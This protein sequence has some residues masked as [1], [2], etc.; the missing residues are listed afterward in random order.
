MTQISELLAAQGLP[1]DKSAV[2]FDQHHPFLV[3]DVN[4]QFLMATGYSRKEVIGNNLGM[5]GGKETETGI[6]RGIL[7]A[8]HA[9]Q[10]HTATI[11]N[12]TKT[13][14]KVRNELT[15]YVIA[16]A[17]GD[18]P[19][20]LAVGHDYNVQIDELLAAKG[21]APDRSAVLFSPKAPFRVSDAN[22]AFLAVTGYSREEVVGNTLGMLAGP[23]TEA[24]VVQRILASCHGREDHSATITNY[25]KDGRKVV[26]AITSYFLP[27][28]FAPENFHAGF[29][30]PGFM[31]VGHDRN[32]AAGQDLVHS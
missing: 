15:T 12:Y 1:A 9:K 30:E 28:G 6:V 5:L 20:F 18:L 13:G 10:A 26:N 19:G 29:D 23:E 7:A 32:I 24:G 16:P 3:T 17:P 8:C 27:K 2:V 25:S 14:T 22:D 31:A 4:E 11:T 21:L